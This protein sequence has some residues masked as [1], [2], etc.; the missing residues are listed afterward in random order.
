M[1]KK[2]LLV[3]IGLASGLAL[4]SAGMYWYVSTELTY[5]PRIKH[6]ESSSVFTTNIS[7]DLERHDL[8]PKY[9]STDRKQ[10]KFRPRYFIIYDSLEDHSMNGAPRFAQRISVP[11]GLS[12]EELKQNL[13]HAAWRLLKEKNAHAVIIWGHRDDDKKRQGGF[14]AGK[15]TLAPYGYWSKATKN[16]DLNSLQTTF[17]LAEVYSKDVPV[18]KIMGDT[19]IRNSTPIY[20]DIANFPD[21]TITNLKKGTR[22]VILE[23]YRDFSTYDFIDWYKIQ[24]NFSKR[25]N[26]AGWVNGEK[27]KE[28]TKVVEAKSLQHFQS[29]QT[30]PNKPS[31][32]HKPSTPHKEWYEGGTLFNAKLHEWRH[33]TYDNKLATCAGLVIAGAEKGI[34]NFKVHEFNWAFVKAR[35]QELMLCIDGYAKGSNRSYKVEN[36]TIPEVAVLAALLLGWTK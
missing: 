4:I 6:I 18:Y 33:A 2:Y 22:V 11:L 36:Q 10:D 23:H 26:Y 7:D 8:K 34:F 19:T 15:C 17:E 21:N 31:T 25:K 28:P 13:S 24:T 12:Q 29:A 30:A 14:T 20:A 3:K 35:A 27:L 5:T 16:F 32:V 9:A 1:S